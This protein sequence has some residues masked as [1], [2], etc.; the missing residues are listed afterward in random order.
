MEEQQGLEPQDALPQG[1]GPVAPWQEA[2]GKGRGQPPLRDKKSTVT[3]GNCADR[4]WQ[5][6]R[7]SWGPTQYLGAG[8]LSHPPPRAA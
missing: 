2:W 5:N 7:V 8:G 6:R 3:G 4:R 1:T